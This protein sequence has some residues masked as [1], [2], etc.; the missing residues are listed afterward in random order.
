M[1]SSNG[2]GVLE[3]DVEVPVTEHVDEWYLE[4]REAARGKLVTVIEVLSPTN[5]LRQPGRKQYLRKR[6]QDFR[7]A[8]QPGRDRLAS[9]GQA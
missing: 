2:P 4:V 1:R 7:F 9:C 3:L 8:D 6:E 5:K